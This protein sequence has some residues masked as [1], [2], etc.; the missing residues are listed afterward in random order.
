MKE[1]ANRIRKLQIDDFYLNHTDPLN[2]PI[3]TF[4]NL[5]DII[6]NLKDNDL[7]SGFCFSIGPYISNNRSVIKSK[8]SHDIWS[9]FFT[10]SENI[11]EPI[12]IFGFC[13]AVLTTS[14]CCL[15]IDQLFLD[16]LVD[17]KSLQSTILKP[18]FLV[19]LYSDFQVDFIPHQTKSLIPIITKYF[20]ESIPMHC[21]LNFYLVNS[22]N[23]SGEELK[24]YPN[25]ENNFWSSL[26]R[27]I[28]TDSFYFQML[29][30]P[31]FQL[32][33]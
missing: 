20:I 24:S 13:E 23:L 26:Y 25:F 28:S 4:L 1:E 29:L 3:N 10:F 2:I 32:E 16:F 12:Q 5:F 27:I 6:Q 30:N 18:S 9:K 22:L 19:S 31:L 21:I 11:N 14:F 8:Y 7:T 33:N 15:S 17:D